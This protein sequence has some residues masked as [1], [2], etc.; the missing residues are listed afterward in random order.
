MITAT[1]QQILTDMK[2]DG[3]TV[4]AGFVAAVIVIKSVKLMIAAASKKIA[5]ALDSAR[6]AAVAAVRS[7]SSAFAQSV[8]ESLQRPPPRVATPTGQQWHAG[9]AALVASS[10]ASSS[11]DS[12]D[13]PWPSDDEMVA[14]VQDMDAYDLREAG[15]V[16]PS[17]D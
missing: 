6:D 7:K 1:L 11:D 17:D 3:L 15:F 2:I 9:T 16:G 12:D 8:R 10:A 5:S 13:T 4:A 14:Y